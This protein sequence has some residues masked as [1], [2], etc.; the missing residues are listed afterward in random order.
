VALSDDAG[1]PISFPFPQSKR[2]EIDLAVSEAW[3]WLEREGRFVAAGLKRQGHAVA[4]FHRGTTAAPTGLDEILGNRN[5]LSA[6][7]QEL[8]RFA[9]DVGD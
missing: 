9:P 2:P 8:Q 5:Q 6:S 1:L 4:V 7:A 3:A